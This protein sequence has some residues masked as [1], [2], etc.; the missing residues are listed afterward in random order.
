MWVLNNIRQCIN[1][2]AHDNG[3]L[4]HTHMPPHTLTHASSHTHAD[5]ITHAHA[6]NI[7]HAATHTNTH[8]NALYVTDFREWLYLLEKKEVEKCLVS[9][10]ELPLLLLLL[11]LL[12][13]L[14]YVIVMVSGGV[15]VVL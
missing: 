2:L 15:N 11:Y 8:P 12:L 5:N 13:L 9:F 3:I 6:D 14:F 10:C 1:S 7:T 4:P